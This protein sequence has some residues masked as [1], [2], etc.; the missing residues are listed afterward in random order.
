MNA[1][2]AHR[3]RRLGGLGIAVAAAGAA[4][5]VFAILWHTSFRYYGSWTV[6][7]TQGSLLVDYYDPPL[8]PDMRLGGRPAGECD[9][10]FFWR[11][12]LGLW[13]DWWPSWR[14]SELRSSRITTITLPL[15]IPTMFGVAV[16]WRAHRRLHARDPAR[17]CWWCRYNRAGLESGARCPECGAWPDATSNRAIWTASQHRWAR[18]RRLATAACAALT[19][20]WLA[21]TQF[22]LQWW[23]TSRLSLGIYGGGV[24]G[25]G[26][27]PSVSDEQ[28]SPRFSIERAAS[29]VALIPLIRIYPNSWSNSPPLAWVAAV[30]L[31]FLPAVAA[32][33]ALLARHRFRVAAR[34]ARREPIQPRPDDPALRSR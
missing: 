34:E 32:G 15:W 7:L 3:R 1:P 9:T 31:W 26:Y 12:P 33:V 18:R 22:V 28:M 20:A 23:V 10:Q 24:V 11:L 27:S 17:R 6:A 30:P 14:T 25:A 8:P 5:W 19:L 21:T 29:D 4:L 13:S 2:P 16:A